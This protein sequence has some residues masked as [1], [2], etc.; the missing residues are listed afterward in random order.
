[1][2]YYC[3]KCGAKF[4]SEHDERAYREHMTKHLDDETPGIYEKAD[5]V[6]YEVL[7][8][9]YDDY[10]SCR[11]KNLKTGR[12]VCDGE[13][14]QISAHTNIG[15]WENLIGKKIRITSFAEIIG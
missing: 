13:V 2:E 4:S 12:E 10:S 9:E 14:Y 7:P 3:E 1:M 6:E 15:L 5:I 8:P 11:L